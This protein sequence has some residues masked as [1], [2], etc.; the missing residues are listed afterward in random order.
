MALI[1]MFRFPTY[2]LC[3]CAYL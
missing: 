2:P 1:A 3:C